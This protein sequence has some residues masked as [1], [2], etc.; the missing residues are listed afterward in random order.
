MCIEQHGIE[1][2]PVE[3]QNKVEVWWL[4]TLHYM[5]VFVSLCI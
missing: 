5:A 2:L 1:Q 3:L 4:Y